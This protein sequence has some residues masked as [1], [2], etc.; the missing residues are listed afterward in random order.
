MISHHEWL[1]FGLKGKMA[2]VAMGL[3]LS[4]DLVEALD[5]VEVVDERKVS[6]YAAKCVKGLRE[7]K[8]DLDVLR[9]QLESLL[10]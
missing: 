2:K 7:V 3:S 9:S 4:K 8:S 10:K 6:Q 1:Q 5:Q